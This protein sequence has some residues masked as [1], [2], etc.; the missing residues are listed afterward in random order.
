[1]TGT[2]EQQ[3]APLMEDLLSHG[4]E[5]TFSQA[6][7]LCRAFLAK[8]GKLHLPGIPWQDRVKVRPEL[9]LSFPAADVASVV[10]AGI[11][12]LITAS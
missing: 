9:S 10:Q 6:M 5:F 3:P 12:F 1:V 8:G 2:T 4:H 11:Y 7:R